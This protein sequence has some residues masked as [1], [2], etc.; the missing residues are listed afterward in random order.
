P[1]IRQMKAASWRWISILALISGLVAPSPGGSG[2]EVW[3]AS[4]V[5]I[6]A[7]TEDAS[8]GHLWFVVQNKSGFDL[9][10]HAVAMGGPFFMPQAPLAQMPA[11][12]AAW[13]DR[14][15]IMFGPR[16][17]TREPVYEVFTLQIHF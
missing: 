14:V 15:W 11:A 2:A 7:S 4:D 3:A 17:G 9:C 6:A 12:L 1:M 5:L 8:G 13:D 10:H 16:I